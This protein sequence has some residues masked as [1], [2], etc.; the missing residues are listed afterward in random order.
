ME[1]KEVVRH[2]LR[3][4]PSKFDALTLS[5]EQY[6]DLDKVSLDEVI[7]SLTV[8]ELWLKERESCEEEQGLLA[9][10]LSK[11]KISTE[12]ESSSHGKGHHQGRGR[13][14]GRGHGQGHNSPSDE[15]KENKSFDKSIIQCY[16]CQKYGHFAYECRSNKKE[17]DDWANVFES[18]PVA[19]AENSSTPVVAATSSLLIALVEEA[20]DLLLH[21]SEGAL[22]DQPLWYLDTGATNHMTGSRNFFCDLN[23]STSGFVKFGDNSTIR[24]EGRGDI[25]I[26]QKD[27][28]ILWLLSVLFVP[29]QMKKVVA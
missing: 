1:V 20:I 28:G 21:G 25:E 16:N 11:S 6:G 2:F 26:N 19:A 23:K 27:G 3:A 4:T 7:G 13:G 10:A 17:Q 9:K 12:E 14:R 22:S 5:L 24:I 29:E 15:D 18:P 8:H